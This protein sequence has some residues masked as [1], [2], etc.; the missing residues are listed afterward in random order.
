MRSNNLT[1]KRAGRSGTF[2][3]PALLTYPKPLDFASTPNVEGQYCYIIKHYG[4]AGLSV[5]I[6][7]EEEN[8]V[9]VCGDWLG[10]ALDLNADDPLVKIA[11]DFIAR[12]MPTFL[13]TMKLV[14][15]EQAQ[16]YFAIHDSGL[17]LVDLQL[18]MNKF[19]SPGMIRDI[20]GKMYHTQDVRKIEV[21]DDRVMAALKRGTGTY[22]GDLIL[23]PSR[24]RVHHLPDNAGVI[25]FYVQIKR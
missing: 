25:P 4:D 2:E 10:N 14:G 5:L 24:F 8:I 11:R 6:K 16:F 19:A 13:Q 12:D 1:K 21:I 17:T 15:F 18:S 23:K 22:E 7:R 20:F 9:V 3:L